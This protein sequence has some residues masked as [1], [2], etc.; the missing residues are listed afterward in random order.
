MYELHLVCVSVLQYLQLKEKGKVKARV[1]K[2]PASSESSQIDIIE[3]QKKKCR[4]ANFNLKMQKR[5]KEGFLKILKGHR[6]LQRFVLKADEDDLKNFE[7]DLKS[8]EGLLKSFK[9]ALE[10][11][12]ES[13]ALSEDFDENQLKTE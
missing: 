12:I 9:N 4:S 3:M 5:F 1:K 10:G 13:K 6:D 8:P 11:K 2:Q 7:N